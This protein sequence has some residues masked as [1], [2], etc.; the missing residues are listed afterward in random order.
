MLTATIV[1]LVIVSLVVVYYFGSWTAFNYGADT[2]MSFDQF[3]ESYQINKERWTIHEE[4]FHDAL[5][6]DSGAGSVYIAMN[7]MDYIRLYR[8]AYDR[9]KQEKTLT[10]RE[11]TDRMHKRMK[12]D[13]QI[14]SMTSHEAIQKILDERN[15]PELHYIGLDPNFKYEAYKYNMYDVVTTTEQKDYIL[16]N[17]KVYVKCNEAPILDPWLLLDDYVRRRNEKL[18][19]TKE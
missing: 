19:I 3:L 15:C 5:S 12:L 6:Y 4:L 8:F 10:K 17:V 2:K 13:A 14:A 11:K 18:G 1:F 7:F 16:Q 9:D